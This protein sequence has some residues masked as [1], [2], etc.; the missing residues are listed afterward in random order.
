[1]FGKDVPK[2]V[3]ELGKH[4]ENLS[5]SGGWF[6]GGGTKDS[7]PGTRRACQKGWMSR[8]DPILAHNPPYGDHG[9]I[10]T[11]MEGPPFGEGRFLATPSLPPK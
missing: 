4:P 2:E 1:M 3:L 7:I 9:T 6:Q 11:Q 10:N 8:G 5:Q